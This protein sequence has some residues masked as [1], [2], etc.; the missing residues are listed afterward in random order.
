MLQQRIS[1]LLFAACLATACAR[2]E[3]YGFIARLGDD[4]TSVEHVRRTGN[5][6]VSDVVER[7]PRVLRKH[8][9]ANLD[10]DGKLR[11]WT[12]TK[13]IMNPSPVESEST[14]YRMDFAAD[15][16][17]VTEENGRSTRRYL[18][19]DVLP[20]TVPWE[21]YVYGLY[22][23]LFERALAQ[24]TDSVAIRQYIP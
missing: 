10:S 7:S 14:T 1:A 20:V 22:E 5:R 18:V 6:I 2:E 9:E 3:E 13:R 24:N 11:D 16:V 21:A 19:S 15:S 8:W 23:L 12:M 4:T 17:V